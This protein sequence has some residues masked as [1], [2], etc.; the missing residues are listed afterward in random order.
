[1][2]SDVR[3]IVF[4]LL[5]R[6]AKVLV[7]E[8]RVPGVYKVGFDAGGPASGVYLCRLTAGDFVNTR[9]LVLLR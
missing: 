6:E 5:D 7:D 3:L 9:K 8:N 2:T 1:M 4:D